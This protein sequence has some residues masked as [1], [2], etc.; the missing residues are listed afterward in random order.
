MPNP[1]W[2]K[3][4]SEQMPDWLEWFRNI[5]LKSYVELAAKFIQLNPYYVPSDDGSEA[6]E[7]F[8]KMIVNRNFFENVTD[9]GVR[10]WAN[11]GFHEFVEALDLYAHRYPEIALVCKL[12]NQNINWFKRIYQFLRAELI[13]E[14]RNDG[15]NL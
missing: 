4:V 11:S 2:S 8:D 6:V 1:V 10:V 15:R 12:F 13:M 5:H 7:I 3:Y 14:L 9:A